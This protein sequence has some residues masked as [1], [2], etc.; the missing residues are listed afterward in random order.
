[1]AE[2]AKVER[3]LYVYLLR[4]FRLVVGEK[5]EDVKACEEDAIVGQET[6]YRISSGP[7]TMY[8]SMSAVRRS[9]DVDVAVAC[10]KRVEARTCKITCKVA[11][12]PT[13]RH[14]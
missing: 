2:C 11:H 8:A 1:M 3:C 6:C 5:G 13:V 9:F 7:I 10:N 12:S 14:A 4:R